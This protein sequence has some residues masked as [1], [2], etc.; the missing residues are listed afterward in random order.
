MAGFFH[1]GSL[2]PVRIR[3]TK[4]QPGGTL[5]ST[6]ITAVGSWRAGGTP[7]ED[8]FPTPSPPRLICRVFVAM[9]PT[10]L[11][12]AS[13]LE[14]AGDLPSLF[15]GVSA[16]TTLLR[17][18]RWQLLAA[19]RWSLTGSPRGQKHPSSLRRRGVKGPCPF[20]ER[21]K[22]ELPPKPILLGSPGSV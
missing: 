12:E 17:E 22:G 2:D 7:K 3:V 15:T 11:V 21:Q 16:A 19:G 6:G 8:P 9:E 18:V 1:Q 20:T 13:P 14:R 10:E 4:C 5:A